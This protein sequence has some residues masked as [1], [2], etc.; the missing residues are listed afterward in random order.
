MAVTVARDTIIC[1][2]CGGRRIVS[3]RQV[4]FARSRGGIPCANCRGVSAG[5]KVSDSDFRFWLRRFGVNA[6]RDMPVREFIAAGG[7]PPDLIEL[8]QQCN[9]DVL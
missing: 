9:P 5:S 7:A 1:P 2:G 3:D 4:R 6:P 8:A